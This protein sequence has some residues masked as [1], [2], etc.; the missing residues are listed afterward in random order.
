[1]G[2]AIGAVKVAA[3][4]LITNPGKGVVGALKVGGKWLIKTLLGKL[5]K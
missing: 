1:M 4:T 3:R 5:L 2:H